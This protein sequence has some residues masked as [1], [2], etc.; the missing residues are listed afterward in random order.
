[1]EVV[2]I[3]SIEPMLAHVGTAIP[4]TQALPRRGRELHIICAADAYPGA[5][6][7]ELPE[8]GP[9]GVQRAQVHRLESRWPRLS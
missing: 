1:M 5:G 7:R 3:Q 8:Y 4:A 2:T 6:A 9:S